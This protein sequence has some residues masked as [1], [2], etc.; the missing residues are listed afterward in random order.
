VQIA[1]IK[2][3]QVHTLKHTLVHPCCHQDA[4]WNLSKDDKSSKED[5]KVCWNIIVSLLYLTAYI[6]DI[7]FGVCLCA[8]LQSDHI[9]TYLTVVK[10]IFRYLKG[11][12]NIGLLYKKSQ[13]YKLVGLCDTDY[14][15]DKIDWKKHQW[16]LS[17]H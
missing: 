11:T 3:V 8:R 17:I 5:Q 14:V 1:K 16:K 6:H 15:G 2:G 12:T 10:R 7:L 9:E 4:T 13:D